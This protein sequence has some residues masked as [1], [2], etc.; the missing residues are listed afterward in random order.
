MRQADTATTLKALLAAVVLASA[1]PAGAHDPRTTARDFQHTLLLE[2][3]PA[4]ALR[5]KALHW[6]PGAYERFKSDAS[7]RQRVNERVWNALGTAEV[8]RELNLAGRPLAKGSYPFGVN[9]EGGDRFALVLKL[10]DKLETIPFETGPSGEVHEYL[11]FTLAPGDKPD[12]FVLEGRCGSFRG[13]V[14]VVFPY[15]AEHAPGAPG[16]H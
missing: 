1:A 6:N 3:Q 15:L 10:G 7:V 4:L 14:P 16:K 5:Y 8:G 12:T 2:G 9:I 11:T 13:R